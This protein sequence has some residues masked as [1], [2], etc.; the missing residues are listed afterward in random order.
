L[1]LTGF[2][3][4]VHGQG[5][6]VSAVTAKVALTGQLQDSSGAIIPQAPV[7][8]RR[9]DGS[10]AATGTTDSGGLFRIAVPAPGTYSLSIVLP[11]FEPLVQSVRIGRAATPPL[12]LSMNLA[13]VATSVT[14]NAD[15]AVDVAAPD[16]NQDAATMSADD[17]KSLPI[18]D[19]DV[20]ATLSAFLD[21]GASGESGASLIVDGVE[22]KTLGVSPSAIERVSINQNPYSAQ[23]RQ[24]GRGQ[25]E[26]IT[27]NTADKFHGAAT[28][29]FRDAS[30]NATNYFA[31]TKPPEQRRTYEGFLTGPIRRF[32]D[33]TFLFSILRQEQ[34]SYEQVDATTALGVTS[35]GNVAAPFRNT[36]LTMKTAHQI[37]DHHSAYLLYRFF[38]SSRANQN[39]G[40]LTLASA[41][42]TA[43]QFDMDITFHDD[44]AFAPN[45]LNQFN[46][47]FE[48][49][50]DRSASAVE[51][52][53]IIVQGAFV[54]G[55]AQND[56]LQ[57]ENNPNIQDIVSWTTH[58][59]HQ[60]KFGVQ[61]PNLGRRVLEDMTDRQGA[62]TYG[63]VP[64]CTPANSSDT[65]CSALNTYPNSPASFTLQQGQT[66][67]LTHY[68]QPG[69]FFLD[70]IQ[71]TERLT[72]TP[73]VRYDFQN[74]LPGTMNAVQPKL[75]L[76]YVLDKKHAMVVRTG[77][78][79]YM[80]RVGVNVGQ[81]LARYQ[82][83]S[84]RSLLLTS[85]VTYPETA[86][87]VAQ[88]PSL[89]NFVPN[90]KAPFQGFFG[91]SVE[92]EVTK[93]STVTLGYEGYRGWHA[94]QSIDINAP[95]PPFT[96]AARP[97]P[98]FAQ[99]LQLHSGGIQR[100]DALI[101]S[102]RGRLGNQFSGFAQYTYQ[103]ARADTEYSTFTPQNQYNPNDEY[104]NTN[105][106]QRHRL[107]LFGTF[108]PDKPLN[109]GIGF[110]NNTGT[111]YTITTGMDDYHTGFFN[112]RPAGV[113]RN[114]LTSGD[115]QDLQVRLGYTRKLKPRL[116]D[117][118]P[119]VA[120]SLSS[121]NTLNRVNF[122]D[123]VGVIT[124]S[125]FMQPASAAGPRRLQLSAG[126]TF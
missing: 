8:L 67:F 122:E 58:K 21:A 119:T 106:D 71:L 77:G 3:A 52:P 56:T 104:G 64:N 105:Q 126:Y 109:L 103:H 112:A 55:G 30:L 14:V 44:N 32:K 73:G 93:K 10:V 123:Y 49:N 124:S 88:P 90:I 101:A 85:G 113:G 117:A 75:A 42:Y 82:Y 74:A 53:Q 13:S 25:V 36:Q 63:A 92:R 70:Q 5:P 1:V 59:I 125:K 35:T 120:L 7:E 51:A 80:R 18:L 66:R 23:Y 11:G 12:K 4:P 115:Y 41:G 110:Y 24:P 43:Y 33:T 87:L 2:T 47:L 97:N 78:G 68:D 34:D 107:A 69:A 19:G 94:L 95:L 76:A 20:V 39:V 91:V 17:M 54:G 99:I 108:Y 22:M 57:T 40:G 98:A 89:F 31:T 6:A 38:D 111:P 46:I 9:A 118:S 83:A 16:N 48:R 50:I 15:E 45:K 27:K 116:K 121:F 26:I 65:H 86:V 114:T 37:S 28:F 102:F 79:I 100:S 72:V 81:Q 29:T 62:Y 61:L 84:E 96:S 60:L